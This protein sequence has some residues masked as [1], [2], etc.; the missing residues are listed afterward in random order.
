MSVSRWLRESTVNRRKFLGQAGA[1]SAVLATAACSST[2]PV[3]ITQTVTPGQPTSSGGVTVPPAGGTTPGAPAAGTTPVTNARIIASPKFGTADMAPT[4][5]VTIT[6]FNATIDELTV[7]GSDGAVVNGA[8]DSGGATWTL[9][10][11]LK[12][13]TV[14]TF[15]GTAT[16][17][18]GTQVPIDGTLTTVNPSSTMGLN[19]VVEEAGTYGVGQPIIVVFDGQ[20][21]NQAAAEKALT[22]T[23]DK[24][25]IV[26]SWGW[27]QDED[28][29]G[30]GLQSQVHW[31]PKEFW[32]AN[33]KVT[34]QADMYGVDFGN[35][36]WGGTDVTRNFTIGRSLV[37]TADVNSFRLK[38]EQ[39]GVQIRDYPVSY[40]KGDDD[41]ATRSGIH[42]V[43]RKY[44]DYDMCNARFNYCGVKVTWAVRIN[45]NGEFIH[46][47]DSTIPYQGIAN[48]SHGCVNMSTANAKDFYDMAIIGDPVIVSGT[49]VDMSEQDFIYDWI[50]S[51]DRW[52]GLSA[53]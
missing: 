5:G 25:D 11:R 30:K 3:V 29:Q 52:K 1:M 22:V 39:D 45:N 49:G 10:D 9:S 6:T 13:N 42:L 46:E 48:V 35:G 20:V 19:W 23:T 2:G 38:V 16:D 51:Y 28:I 41:R 40:G 36:S 15:A 53:L 21:S 17:T 14:Y 7:T 31:R 4:A 50:Y 37:V 12:F 27:L 18:A 34:V 44:P 8:L 26:G 24:G 33:T 32:P 43:Q 47:N